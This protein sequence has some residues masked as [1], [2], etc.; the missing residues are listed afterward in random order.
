RAH[1]PTYV[2]K[3]KTQGHRH[4]SQLSELTHH[5]QRTSVIGHFPP[6]Q[7]L[8]RVPQ[9]P[10]SAV[11]ALAGTARKGPWTGD[12]PPVSTPR[13]TAGSRAWNQRFALVG[14]LRCSAS[15]VTRLSAALRVPPEQVVAHDAVF[16]LLH[17]F[18]VGAV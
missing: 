6:H 2:T 13:A 3:L 12:A 16:E 1:G 5:P 14:K 4:G 15:T 10:S 17:T 9:V 18:D 8:N 11:T 7:A